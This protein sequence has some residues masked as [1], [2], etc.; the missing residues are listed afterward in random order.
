MI[1][2]DIS[3]LKLI[4]TYFHNDYLFKFLGGFGCKNKNLGAFL[5]VK[6]C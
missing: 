4:I 2:A 6:I 1:F 5:G 3:A